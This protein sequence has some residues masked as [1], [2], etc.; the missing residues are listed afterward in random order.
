MVLIEQLNAPGVADRLSALSGLKQEIVSGARP[1]P[2][3]LSDVNNHIH[4][5]YSFSPYS[6]T[7]AVWMAYESGLA[8][9]GLIDHDSISGAQE[10]VEAGRIIGMPVTVGLECRADVSKTPL[11]GKT[12]NNPDQ[13]S[14]VYMGIHGVPHTRI[15]EAEAFF[16]PYK[17]ARMVRN[18]KM[19]ENINRLLALHGV[20]LD[21]DR[22]VL[23]L[24]QYQA[25]GTVTERHILFAL[26]HKLVKK[27][28]RGER[29]ISF[30][31]DSLKLPLPNKI[32]Y[33]LSDP[34]NPHYEYDLLGVLKSGFVASMY[35]D[36]TDECP[37]VREVVRFA[38]SIGAIAAYAYLGDVGDSVTGDKKAQ[39][40]EDDYLDLLFEVLQDVG[41]RAVTYMPT[42]NTPE[43]LERLKSYCAKYHMF[44]ICGED[45]NTPRQV[46]VC[47]ALRHPEFSN[48]I[49]AAWALIGHEILASIDLSNAFLSEET[50]KRFPDLAERTKYFADFARNVYR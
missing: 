34:E 21:F 12:V 46:F 8:T 20:Q 29:L 13:A 31:R 5:T 38:D 11:A 2:Q 14:V 1:C 26:A 10:F 41:F 17:E 7:K 50:A 49:E 47:E 45:I 3:R 16:K 44:E 32:F 43:Q 33:Y 15:A 18:R 24:S 36:A 23:P 39:K 6:P 4:T 19:V 40:F 22:D 37:D 42:R 25:G 28:G 48:L 27:Y 30:L 35:V 9:A